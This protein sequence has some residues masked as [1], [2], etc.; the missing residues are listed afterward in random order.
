[1]AILN[2]LYPPIV[3]TYAPAF[4][5]DSASASKNTCKIYFSI[6]LYNSYSDIKNAQVSVSSQYTNAS[7]L[8]DEKYP[9]EIMVTSIYEDREKDS[10]DKYYIEIKKSDMKDE[11]FEINQYYKVQ[12]RFTSADAADVS[13]TTPQSIDSWLAANSGYFSEWSTVCLA[14]GISTPSLTIP[15]F[16]SSAG[17]TVWTTDTITVAGNLTFL[18]SEE[19]ETLK[20]YRILL[21]NDLEELLSDSGI[22]YTNNYVGVNEIN[23]TFRYGFLD[24]ETYK[25]TIEYTTTNL[26]S[27]TIEYTFMVVLGA[28]GDMDATLTA[29]EDVENGR[30][31]LYI[32][33]NTAERYTGNITIRRTSSDDNFIL[34]DDI[35]TMSI[36]NEFLDT[37]W[38]DHTIESGV[39]YKYCIQERDSYGNRGVVTELEDPVM[40]VLDHMC[41]TT[42]E[43]QLNV[44]FDPQISSF[45]YV[46][47]ES[48][49]TAIGSKYPYIKRNGYTF[50]RQFPISGLISCHIDTDGL[51]LATREE[52][53]QDTLELYDDYNS[54][55][56]ITILNDYTYERD[57]REAV[58]EFLYDN[59]VKLFRSPTEGNILVKLTDIS[60]T[61]NQ[62]LG[63]MLYSFSCTATEIDECSV[64]NFNYY[65]I[66]SSGE[67]DEELAY[68]ETFTGQLNEVIPAGTDVLDVLQEKY[69]KLVQ[70]GYICSVDYLDYLRL[71][72]TEDPYLIK[73]GADEPYVVDDEYPD[74]DEE[75]ASAYLGYLV[76]IN[77]E[78]FVINKEGIYELKSEDVKITSLVF[79]IDT[80]INMEYHVTISQTE[81]KTQ[82]PK[83]IEYTLRVGQ[84]WG[85]FDYQDSIFQTI[86]NKY[87]EKYSTYIQS[88]LSLDAIKIEAEPGTVVYVAETGESELERHIIGE[89]C[90]L[91][92]EDE[93]ALITGLYFAGIH[94]EEAIDYEKSRTLLPNYRYVDTGITVNS[95]DE[96]LFPISNG[97][98]TL[99]SEEGASNILSTL[100]KIQETSNETYSRLLLRAN[101]EQFISTLSETLSENKYI[102]YNDKWWLFTD[103]HDLLCPVEALIDYTCELSTGW[104]G[105]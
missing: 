72:L 64:D 82:L 75:P 28:A 9:S 14:R 1:M 46:V 66:Q 42:S 86:W 10:D 50:Y 81:D 69:N 76:Y 23:Y 61:P 71:E 48:T 102:W 95:L 74:V 84:C 45:K 56:R 91:S 89:T 90:T 8:N 52:I 35:Y 33:G 63:R 31:G 25:M 43:Q 105:E 92:F 80:E 99:S 13:L 37:T 85:T 24:G 55:N 79:P 77:G 19:T 36:E 16:D 62:T 39:W 20:S 87:Y 51:L 58:M 32:K 5:V 49:T 78:P 97:V 104:Y 3:D 47:T 44:K 53:Y 40:I 57:F 60:F 94:F 83:T 103:D 54:Q 70:E 4:L 98:Y 93:G 27:E 59:N 12:I 100:M 88:L 26:Y 67:L 15:G 6:S 34:W 2:N 29:V 7:C 68:E 30:I 11:T 22:T 101:D 41:L 21:Y 65:N 18:D 38:Y 73:E 17:Y 96:V